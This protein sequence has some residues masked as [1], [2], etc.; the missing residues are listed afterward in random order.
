MKD[1][2]HSDPQKM[3]IGICEQCW[4]FIN[5]QTSSLNTLGVFRLSTSFFFKKTLFIFNWRVFVLQYCVSFCH[6]S[7]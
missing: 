4:E 6:T 7:T 5:H 1:R 3:Q 2:D